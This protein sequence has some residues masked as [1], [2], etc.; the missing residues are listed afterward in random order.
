MD[1]TTTRRL[2]IEMLVEQA[3]GPTEFGRRIEREQAQ[4]SQWTSTTNPKPI[5][6]RL[7]RYIEQAMGLDRGWLDVPHQETATESHSQSVRL[8]PETVR[9]VVQVLQQLYKD[10]LHRPYVITDEPEVFVELY[11]RTIERG[12]TEGNLFWL[13]TRVRGHAPQGG[14]GEERKNADDRGHRKRNA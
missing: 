3:G 12:S 4:V 10:E 2:N 11:Q 13:G 9:D 5:G 8:D 7:A 6:G 14:T 1:V